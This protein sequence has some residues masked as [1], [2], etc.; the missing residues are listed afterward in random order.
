MSRPIQPISTARLH[1]TGHLCAQPSSPRRPRPSRARRLARL[2]HRC[3]PFLPPRRRRTESSLPPLLNS[4]PSRRRAHSTI[5]LA[6]PSRASFSRGRHRRCRLLTS[7]VRS[8]VLSR[9]TASC[10]LRSCSLVARP[11]RLR[12]RRPRNRSRRPLKP[13]S[14]N[15][16]RSRR[17]KSRS[18]RA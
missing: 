3:R 12:P 13:H 15:G 6:R 11:P 16:V 8:S 14:G 10:R 9:M 4:R 5:P 2:F 18:G 1:R 17:K 7:V